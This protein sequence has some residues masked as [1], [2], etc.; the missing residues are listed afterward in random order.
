M[1]DFRSGPQ[2]F[3]DYF[4]NGDTPVINELRGVLGA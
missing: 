4:V 3:L 1:V 2:N